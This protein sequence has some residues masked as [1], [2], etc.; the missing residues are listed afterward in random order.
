MRAGHADWARFPGR[1]RE[2]ARAVDKKQPFPIP[3][4]DRTARRRSALWSVSLTAPVPFGGWGSGGAPCGR[5]THSPYS[6]SPLS[7]EPGPDPESCVP[8]LSPCTHP[9]IF[10]SSPVLPLLPSPAPLRLS[11]AGV[12]IFAEGVLKVAGTALAGAQPMTVRSELSCPDVLSDAC[13]PAPFSRSRGG[14]QA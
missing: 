2:R 8:C 11:S 9:E 6:P 3:S 7:P 10:S 13:T 1:I 12:P 5:F 4:R 14:C